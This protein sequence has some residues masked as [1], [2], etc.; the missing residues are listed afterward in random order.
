MRR[1]RMIAFALAAACALSICAGTARAQTPI[2]DFTGGVTD[3]AT[4]ART[5]TYGFDFTVS[6]DSRTISALGF[7]DIG[8]D[9]LTEPHEVGLW[10][11][12]G[13]LLASTT[14]DNTATPVTSTSTI[15]RWLTKDI[16]PITLPPGSYILG[17][18][19][20]ADSP[21][22]LVRNAVASSISGVTHGTTRFINIGGGLLFPTNFIPTSNAGVFGPMAFIIAPL[23]NVC[24]RVRF[25][26]RS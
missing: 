2:T 13:N 18:F 22:Y 15:G 7:F 1:V 23:Y 16:T 4:S 8:S 5:V 14:I 17:A 25:L 3:F 12:A 9:G 11:S 24:L 19:Y 6:G 20:N 21:D 10:D 26:A